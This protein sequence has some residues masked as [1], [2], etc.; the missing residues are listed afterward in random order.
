[1]LLWCA[2]ER[3]SWRDGWLVPAACFLLLALL[4]VM[5]HGSPTSTWLHCLFTQPQ[6]TVA[7]PI[8]SGNSPDEQ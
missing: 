2:A 6:L 7:A 5:L 4:L 3:S 8:N 1:M